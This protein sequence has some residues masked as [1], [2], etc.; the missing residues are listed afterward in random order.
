M[1]TAE[2]HLGRMHVERMRHLRQRGRDDRAVEVLHE[3][4]GR[5]QRNDER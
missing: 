3:K 5:D 1:N 2:T 4:R